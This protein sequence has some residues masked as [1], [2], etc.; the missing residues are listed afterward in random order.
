MYSPSS[1]VYH[2]SSTHVF[3]KYFAL[4][5]LT[6]PKSEWDREGYEAWYLM[7][8]LSSMVRTPTVSFE[9]ETVMPQYVAEE[10]QKLTPLTFP[11]S[12]AMWDREGYVIVSAISP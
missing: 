11:A 7:P 6:D 3:L 9:N 12:R 8:P 4:K 2:Q 1:S 10:P 5:I